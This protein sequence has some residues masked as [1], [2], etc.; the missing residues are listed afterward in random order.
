[1]FFVYII[2]I[3]IKQFS[4]EVSVKFFFVVSLTFINFGHADMESDEDKFE[5]AV[6]SFPPENLYDCVICN[7]STPSTKE[8]PILLVSLLQSTSGES[9]LSSE[10]SQNISLSNGYIFHNKI[11]FGMT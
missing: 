10:L 4:C 2:I 11:L 9:T 5:D 6:P 7:Q 3:I 1:M 8:R